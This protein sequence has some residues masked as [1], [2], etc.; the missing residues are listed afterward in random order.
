MGLNIFQEYW[1]RFKKPWCIAFSLYL[2]FV[3]IILGGLGVLFSIFS[4]LDGKSTQSS[5][6]NSQ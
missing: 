2:V 4:S 1:E 6:L 5:P 3:I